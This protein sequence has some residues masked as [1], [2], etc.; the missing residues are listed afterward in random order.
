MKT[1]HRNRLTSIISQV[2]ILCI[3]LTVLTGCGT[4][5][6][7]T[8]ITEPELQAQ[9]A[10]E[11]VQDTVG[12]SAEVEPAGEQESVISKT[13]AVTSQ[14]S[15][16]TG[17]K[18]DNKT[19]NKSEASDKLINPHLKYT[20]TEKDLLSF[21]ADVEECR[22]L[23]EQTEDL[24]PAVK[25]LS[26]LSEKFDKIASQANIAYIL[27]CCDLTD[28]KAADRYSK[29]AKIQ[30]RAADK[31]IAIF[32]DLYNSEESAY[33]ELFEDWSEADLN[34]LIILSDEAVARRER[35]TDIQMEVMTLTEEEA[36]EKIGSLYREYVENS[37]YIAKEYGYSDAYECCSKTIYQRTL[38][39][40]QR[41]SFRNYVKKYIVPLYI[42][43]CNDL[44]D[45]IDKLTVSE[46][47]A[48]QQLLERDY[49]EVSSKRIPK[50]YMKNYFNSLSDSTAKYMKDMFANKN[51]VMTDSEK[52][53]YGAYNTEV[54]VPFCFFGPGMQSAFTVIHELG[55]YYAAAAGD[56]YSGSMDLCETQS[57]GNEM[58]F[59]AYLKSALSDNL[60]EA[61]GG[62][63]L[64][65]MLELIIDGTVM[66]EF[67]EKIYKGKLPA[68]ADG[69][70]FDR[71]MAETVE[72]YGD[73]TTA[74]WFL[75]SMLWRWR[76]D[77]ITNPVYFLSYAVSAE[78]AINLYCKAL[79]DYKGAAE[80]YRLLAEGISEDDTYVQTLKKAGI[81]SPFEESSYIR[82]QKLFSENRAGRG[83]AAA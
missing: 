14:P 10:A 77:G 69:D 19:G 6:N 38:T 71:I 44:I 15:G 55:H 83:Q 70:Y 18:T 17:K 61:L 31:Y 74:E 47:K 16:Q 30:G 41:E 63:K 43:S 53:Y 49:D 81:A 24:N 20:L 7:Q 60:A 73:K 22:G 45:A 1:K 76:N 9:S 72:S 68:D 58:L 67:E 37:N 54:G 8:T 48:L 4:G 23:L 65:E 25:K 5:S 28:E 56:F 29:A 79:E 27:Y 39:K 40:D 11:Q 42:E 82:L 26:E 75:E 35:N 34:D 46:R 51:C 3:L 12:E 50:G 80:S 52:A 66:D 62:Y 33:K 57:Q 21:D 64:A 78:A 32:T 36:E 13:Q 2:L 59:T